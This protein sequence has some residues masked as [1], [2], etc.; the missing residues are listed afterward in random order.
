MAFIKKA[1]A[2][3][4]ES[5]PDEEPAVLVG[6]TSV[7]V[8]VRLPPEHGGARITVTSHEI[9]RCP[10]GAG[11]AMH[12]TLDDPTGICVAECTHGHGFMWYR[13]AIR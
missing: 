6:D 1:G 2:T 4:V 12:L 10:C 9:A 3:V 5:A 7:P 11:T 8:W 13:R